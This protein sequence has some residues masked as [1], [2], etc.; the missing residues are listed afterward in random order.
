MKGALIYGQKKIR[1]KRNLKLIN[2]DKPKPKI[3]CKTET[4][5]KY[6]LFMNDYY[7]NKLLLKK[8]K[9]ENALSEEEMNDNYNRY[10]LDKAAELVGVSKKSLDDYLL[11]IRL[12]RKYGFNF[13]E[14]KYKKVSLRQFC[15]FFT[16]LY[17]G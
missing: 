4:K 7:K 16:L 5:N 3:M 8:R 12:G 14:N 10:S 9:L 13:N 15:C 2:K 1:K 11:Q 17:L 6:L